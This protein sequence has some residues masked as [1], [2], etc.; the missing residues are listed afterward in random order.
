[1][2]LRG[3]QWYAHSRAE[4]HFLRPWLEVRIPLFC[5]PIGSI[6]RVTTTHSIPQRQQV[7]YRQVRKSQWA[8]TPGQIFDLL[9]ILLQRNKVKVIKVQELADFIRESCSQLFRFTARSN[10]LADAHNRLIAVA[11]YLRL[12]DRL[13]THGL[14][15]SA[16][17]KAS[18]YPRIR[19][20]SLLLQV[21]KR[22]RKAKRFYRLPVSTDKG[23][24]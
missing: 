21:A 20:D 18:N 10:R 16:E 14:I 23:R 1:M 5:V 9:G 22:V 7:F 19:D 6:L 8:L 12:N 11:V 13:C 2:A 4:A 24:N 17:A 15:V 3:C